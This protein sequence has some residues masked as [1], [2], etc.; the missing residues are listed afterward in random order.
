MA[1][2]PAS[3]ERCRS[4]EEIQMKCQVELAERNQTWG[5]PDWIKTQCKSYYPVESCY[6]EDQ[7]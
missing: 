6:I 7:H 2:G 4:M 5:I 1:C 3:T